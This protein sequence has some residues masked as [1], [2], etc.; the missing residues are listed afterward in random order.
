MTDQLS[1]DDDL[2]GKHT[3]QARWGLQKSKN[4]QGKENRASITE[5]IRN[6]V[7]KAL[8]QSSDSSDDADGLGSRKIYFNVPLP[9]EA[10]DEDG[11]PKAHYG[12]N[13]IRTAKYTPLSFVP[14]NLFFQF[15]N[16]A[17]DYFLF[18]AILAVSSW[19]CII[20]VQ[21]ISSRSSSQYSA[22]QIPASTPSLLSL[23]SSSLP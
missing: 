4:N 8:G 11:R 17:N 9:N 18:L 3:W 10:L 19:S 14:K 6:A 13:K 12:R 2:N 1:A 15:Q 7:G 22:F 23:L 5:R 16:I 21:L 20:R